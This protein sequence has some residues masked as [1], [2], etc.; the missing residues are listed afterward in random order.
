MLKYNTHKDWDVTTQTCK[1]SLLRSYI[2][3][4]KTTTHQNSFSLLS[5]SFLNV[6][7]LHFSISAA[8]WNK[9]IV[10]PIN[11]TQI[12]SILNPSHLQGGGSHDTSLCKQKGLLPILLVYIVLPLYIIRED[13]IVRKDTEKY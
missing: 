1:P 11:Y 9:G 3:V 2:I 6:S 4:N 13:C 7:H 12:R 8:I 10:R 5:N